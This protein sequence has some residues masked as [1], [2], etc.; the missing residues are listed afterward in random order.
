MSLKEAKH[1]IPLAGRNSG[2]SVRSPE[3]YR[4][5]AIISAPCRTATAAFACAGSRYVLQCPKTQADSRIRRH[6]PVLPFEI[7]F[8]GTEYRIQNVIIV[9]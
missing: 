1:F 5:Y 7:E 2:A 3:Q 4:S 9:V 6:Y 8:T